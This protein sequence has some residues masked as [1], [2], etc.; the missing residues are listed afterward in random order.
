ARFS[1]NLEMARSTS[2]AEISSA[3]K[4]KKSELLLMVDTVSPLIEDLVFENQSTSMK[5]YKTPQLNPED[6]R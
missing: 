5:Q 6:K 3:L 1:S 4:R 2:F